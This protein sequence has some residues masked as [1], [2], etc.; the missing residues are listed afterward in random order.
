MLAKTNGFAG[1]GSL[2]GHF[3][4]E[5]LGDGRLYVEE[6]FAP[7]VLVR[8]RQGFVV[9]NFREPERTSAL[10]DEMARAWPDRVTPAAP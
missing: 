8:L 9:V 10:Y 1:A 7:Y 2:R 4:V 3:R 5:G 6:G